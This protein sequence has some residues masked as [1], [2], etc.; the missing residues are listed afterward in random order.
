MYEAA[1]KI[2]ASGGHRWH[3]AARIFII[4]ARLAAALLRAAPFCCARCAHSRAFG[5]AAAAL[6]KI[7]AWRKRNGSGINEKW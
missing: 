4:A 5:C 1:K 7:M 2:M 6:S 3:G